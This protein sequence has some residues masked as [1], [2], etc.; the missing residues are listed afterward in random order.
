MRRNI[1]SFGSKLKSFK[2]YIQADLNNEEGFYQDPVITFT[3][4]FSGM[5]ELKRKE[6]D[7]PYSAIIKHLKAHCIKKIKVLK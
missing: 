3:L 7:L 4:K 6:E 2:Q 5:T 1:I